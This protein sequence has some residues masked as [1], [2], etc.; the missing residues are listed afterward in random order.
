MQRN[1]ISL[2]QTN[3]R[4]PKAQIGYVYQDSTGSSNYS[5]FT[6][7]QRQPEQ[8]VE[9]IKEDE[10][11]D[12]ALDTDQL[13]G[14]HKGILNKCATS[15]GMEYGDYIRML[16]LDDEEKE[17]IKMNKLLEAEKA[18]YSV[19]GIKKLIKY[20]SIRFLFDMNVIRV[21]NHAERDGL[22]KSACE[23]KRET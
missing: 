22:L 14:E 2:F 10:D 19:K 1:L 3:G 13:T 15:F 16:I 23:E 21:V 9:P 20:F 7:N 11:L 8:P 6:V 18:Q 12:L 17:K 5:N 4:E